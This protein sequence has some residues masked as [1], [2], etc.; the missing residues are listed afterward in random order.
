MAFTLI[1]GTFQV[2]NYSPDGDSIRFEPE[3]RSL[4]EGLQNGGRAKF[5]A[6]GHVQLRI[7]AI[8]TLET[9]FTPPSGGAILHQPRELAKAAA[10]GLLEFTGISDVVWDDR[11]NTVISASDGTP[12]YILARAVEKNGRP[13]A[14]VFTGEPEQADGTDVF[15]DVELLKTSY[16]WQ[17]ISNGMAYPTFYKGL[18]SQLRNALSVEA[19]A[20]RAAGLGVYAN[21]GTLDGF[22]AS[23]LK[24]ITDEVPILPK[25]FRRLSDYIVNHSSAL[26]FK[27]ALEESREPVLDLRETNFTHFGN[28]VEQEPGSTFIRLNRL[29]EEMVFDETIPQPGPKFARMVAGELEELALA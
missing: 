16:N 19:A 2:L 8:D 13:I 12:G 11:R 24:A 27:E 29:P 28:L 21:D 3:D 9:H 7:E 14:F 25:L 17:A 5:N 18:F 15:L 23:T 6:R 4:V 22:D 20:A 26:G 10:E 1:K